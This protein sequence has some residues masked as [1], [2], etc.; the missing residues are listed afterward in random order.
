MLAIAPVALADRTGNL[1]DVA[2][3]TLDAYTQLHRAV[4]RTQ[5]TPGL[6]VLTPLQFPVA[7]DPRMTEHEREA[8]LVHAAQRVGASHV[9]VLESGRA[10]GGAFGFSQTLGLAQQHTTLP[11]SVKI[12]GV[13][14]ERTLWREDFT[15]TV[16][17]SVQG[18]DKS[19]VRGHI[20][21][22][23]VTRFLQTYGL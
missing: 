22:I 3:A 20:V 6:T 15:V 4:Q 23:G 17:F 18:V 11:V 7:L 10:E 9:L 2:R 12:L 5:G 8:D 19:A 14:A 16:Q 1:G 13:D 21:G